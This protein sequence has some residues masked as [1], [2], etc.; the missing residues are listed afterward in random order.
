MA[1]KRPQETQLI[2]ET[3]WQ[4]QAIESGITLARMSKPS[5][6]FVAE[7]VEVTLIF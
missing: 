3:G 1:T 2:N 4:N 7:G 5:A 6:G